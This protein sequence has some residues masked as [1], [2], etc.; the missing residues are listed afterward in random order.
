MQG[1]SQT[2]IEIARFLF[3]AKIII[4]IIIKETK[5]LM[6]KIKK[7]K[8]N[9]QK[10]KTLKINNTD[11]QT[12]KITTTTLVNLEKLEVKNTSYHISDQ[13]FQKM[14]L[15]SNCLFQESIRDQRWGLRKI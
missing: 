15:I 9:I 7:S 11:K 3:C 12:T 2:N 8:K 10:K 5:L 1:P 6:I 4:I 14:S 13:V